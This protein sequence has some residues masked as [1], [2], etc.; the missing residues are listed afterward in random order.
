MAEYVHVSHPAHANNPVIESLTQLS[1]NIQCPHSYIVLKETVLT[2]K[3]ALSYSTQC[4]QRN[5]REGPG[6][7]ALDISREQI[8]YLS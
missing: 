5:G 4:V 2:N 3:T 7:P 8:E 1:R 6:R